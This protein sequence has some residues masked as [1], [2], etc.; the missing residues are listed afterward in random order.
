M[1]R[2]ER[3]FLLCTWLTSVPCI[4]FS[5]LG[6]YSGNFVPPLIPGIIAAIWW[7]A[8]FFLR[9]RKKYAFAIS[10]V[11]VNLLWWPLLVQ[12][13]RR[14]HFVIVNGALER[15]DGYGSPAAFLLGLAFEQFSFIPAS[16][17]IARAVV[18]MI[19]R[20]EPPRE[21]D[22]GSDSGGLQLPLTSVARERQN[23]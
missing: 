6:I 14:M 15:V 3:T 16:M 17:V 2:Y 10:L 8:Y 1:N 7:G 21:P 12:S 18:E 9:S 22:A 20:G 11:V 4:L 13:I 23:L 5:I 19:S